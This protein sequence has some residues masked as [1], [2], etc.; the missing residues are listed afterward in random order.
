MGR[1]CSSLQSQRKEAMFYYRTVNG[2]Q[3]PIKVMTLG[4]ILVKKWNHLSVQ[5]SEIKE[6]KV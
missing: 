4:R 2:L 6:R 5:V 1:L 3:T